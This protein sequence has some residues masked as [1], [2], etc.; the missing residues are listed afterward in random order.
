MYDPYVSQLRLHEDISAPITIF[1]LWGIYLLRLYYKY[2]AF[3]SLSSLQIEYTPLLSFK[4]S[5][6]EL[7]VSA[8]TKQA[9]YRSSVPMI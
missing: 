5:K 2:I 6:M 1:S 7:G 3:P 4:L 9:F 8:H